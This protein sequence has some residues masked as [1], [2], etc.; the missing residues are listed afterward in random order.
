MTPKIVM[1]SIEVGDSPKSESP[2]S[3]GKIRAKKFFF[4]VFYL[5]IELEIIFIFKL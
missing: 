3:D 4:R 2:E 5:K 1:F